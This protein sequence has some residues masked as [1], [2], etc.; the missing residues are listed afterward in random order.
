MVIRYSVAHG[1]LANQAF[2][3]GKRSLSY[4]QKP[5]TGLKPGSNERSSD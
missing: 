4:S 3:E 2:V 5:V 1:H